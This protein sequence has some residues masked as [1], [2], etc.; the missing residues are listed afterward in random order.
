MVFVMG[1]PRTLRGN[2]VIWVSIDWLTKFAYFLVMKV[3]FSIDQLVFLYVKEN[4]RMHKVL[5]FIVSDKDPCFSSQLW[6]S[7]QK[8]LGT[9]LSFNIVFHP[10][11]NGQ[12]EK[13]IQV[14][15]DLLRACALD[16]KGNWDD[17]LPLVKFSYNNGFQSSTGMTPFEGFYGR[18]CQPPIC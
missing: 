18:R 10:Q 9:N 5:F 15:E 6:H 16:L 4:V 14:L 7:L 12:L 17:F 11:M 13:V 1:F 2:N 3:S 8:A